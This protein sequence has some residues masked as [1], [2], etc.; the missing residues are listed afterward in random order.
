MSGSVML[1]EDWWG[2]GKR[3]SRRGRTKAT[4]RAVKVAKKEVRPQ[5]EAEWDSEYPLRLAR[6][7]LELFHNVSFI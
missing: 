3:G 5:A 1:Q 2:R 7:L 4:G 6:I